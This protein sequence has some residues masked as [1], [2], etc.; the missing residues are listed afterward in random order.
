MANSSSSSDMV[1]RGVVS[2]FTIEHRRAT[3]TP[4]YRTDTRSCTLHVNVGG[5]IYF[6]GGPYISAQTCNIMVRGDHIFR[7]T[8]YYF[9]TGTV[10]SHVFAALLTSAVSCHARYTT[11]SEYWWWL[12]ASRTQQVLRGWREKEGEGEE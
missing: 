5:A 2:S 4:P 8:I 7:G 9:V 11:C 12:W 10:Q 1:D 3:F 6:R